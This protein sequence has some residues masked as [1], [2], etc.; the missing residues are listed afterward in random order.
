MSLY[1]RGADRAVL[2]SHLD[3]VSRSGRGELLAVQGRRQLGKSTLLT[4]FTEVS[5]TPHLYATAVKNASTRTQLRQLGEAAR[6]SV[7]PLPQNDLLFRETPS[8]WS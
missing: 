7:N 3:R 8:S 2:K 5:N 6:Q 4:R 1:G